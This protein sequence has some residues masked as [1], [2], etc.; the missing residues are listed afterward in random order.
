MKTLPVTAVALAMGA[1][2]EVKIALDCPPDPQRC[3]SFV[4]ANALFEHLKAAGVAI[5][6]IPGENLPHLRLPGGISDKG[7]PT[8]DQGDRPVAVPLHMGQRHDWHQRT[9]MQTC[10]CRIKPDI[11][12]HVFMI[13]ELSDQRLIGDLFDKAPLPKYVINAFQRLASTFTETASVAPTLVHPF[14]DL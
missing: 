9:D 11:A 1:R 14:E 5:D 6:L 13:E 3:G 7:G 2:A 10:R 8:P 12:G 4:F